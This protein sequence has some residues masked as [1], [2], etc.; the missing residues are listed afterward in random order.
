MTRGL[1]VEKYVKIHGR[2]HIEIEL[3]DRKPIC[4]NSS[5]LNSTIGFMVRGIVPLECQHWSDVSQEV[6]KEIVE[7]LMVST[8]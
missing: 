6:K 3:E 5:S 7:R 4:R 1:A 2:I 8:F